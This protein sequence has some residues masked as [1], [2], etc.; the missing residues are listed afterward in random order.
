MKNINRDIYD[1]NASS[2]NN[3]PGFDLFRTNNKFYFHFNDAEGECLLFS[4]AYESRKSAKNGIKSVQTNIKK[5]G[6]IIFHHDEDSQH[7]T[8]KAGNNQ[9]IARSRNFETMEDMDKGLR[10][11]HKIHDTPYE[12][13]LG[14]DEIIENAD[15]LKAET[16]SL[17][18]QLQERDTIE[19]ELREK[20]WELETTIAET[21][22]SLNESLK[23]EDT[24]EK[25]KIAY[26]E[27]LVLLTKKLSDLNLNNAQSTQPEHSETELQHTAF[28]FNLKFYNVDKAKDLK[29]AIKPTFSREQRIIEGFDKEKLFNF[30]VNKLPQT[31]LPSNDL[32]KETIESNSGSSN[33]T[34]SRGITPQT[35]ATTPPNQSVNPSQTPGK[36]HSQQPIKSEKN[37]PQESEL[38]FASEEKKFKNIKNNQQMKT[39]KNRTK[40][41]TATNQAPSFVPSE[42]EKRIIE[43]FFGKIQYAEATKPKPAID[44]TTKELELSNEELAI[45]QKFF[46]VLA[47]VKNQKQVAASSKT[48]NRGLEATKSQEIT[49]SKEEL[50]IISKFF[51][52]QVTPKD[53]TRA[54]SSSEA[55]NMILEATKSQEI[56]F[57]E[58]E[59]AIIRQFFPF[60]FA[61]ETVEEET[62][63]LDDLAANPTAEIEED[64]RYFFG[65]QEISRQLT[66]N[67]VENKLEAL[68]SNDEPISAIDKEELAIINRIFGKKN[69]EEETLTSNPLPTP[70]PINNQFVRVNSKEMEEVRSLFQIEKRTVLKPNINLPN[71]ENDPTKKGTAAEDIMLFNKWFGKQVKS[72]PKPVTKS[73]KPCQ[74][75]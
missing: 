35:V 10:F 31:V 36:E 49:L 26:D 48:T 19:S 59:L 55:T 28:G 46:P 67:T 3:E 72:I 62:I 44:K 61:K 37:A 68:L 23:K 5:R 33:L 7:F 43:K 15:V 71:L 54:I 52:V 64:V 2:P 60:S 13:I 18:I 27:K 57:S 74:R 8:I 70:N 21:S 65:N 47:K 69:L 11:I 9:E 24:W 14:H 30:M 20:I 40:W 16:A 41:N 32:E 39:L 73:C 12:S 22:S 58:E 6:R 25:E 38:N 1:L 66:N 17:Q 42:E 29:I 50:A 4:Q 51:P 45:I 63:K 56:T 53:Q 75:N 34:H